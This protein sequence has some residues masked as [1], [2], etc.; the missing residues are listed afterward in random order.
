MPVGLGDLVSGGGQPVP[1][2]AG[3][4]PAHTQ[5]L[6]PGRALTVVVGRPPVVAAG[7]QRPAGAEDPVGPRSPR[8]RIHP[9][10]EFL[11]T[12][13]HTHT[14]GGSGVLPAALPVQER[15][16]PRPPAG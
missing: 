14:G 15:D 2:A 16:P 9:V 10:P 6:R 7:W 12:V 1:P 13:G 8:F 11:K 3:G 5:T 4:D